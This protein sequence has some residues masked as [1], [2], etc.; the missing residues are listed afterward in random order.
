MMT[1]AVFFRHAPRRT[2]AGPSA[3]GDFPFRPY[4]SDFG[5]LAWATD[6]RRASIRC[7]FLLYAVSPLSDKDIRIIAF[8]HG[9][10]G[11]VNLL[12]RFFLDS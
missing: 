10:G 5:N 1:V 2:A 8:Y 7:S 4:M 6:E 11:A 12:D 3:F 9:S